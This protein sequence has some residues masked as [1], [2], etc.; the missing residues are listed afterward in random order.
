MSVHLKK[1]KLKQSKY[2]THT[3]Y[4]FNLE[5]LHQTREF[6]FDTAVTVFV[7]ENGSGKSTLLEACARA[8]RIHIWQSPGD[9]RYDLNLYEDQLYR[10]L[11]PEWTKGRVSGAFFAAH[12]FKD[13]TETLD[14]W[15]AADPG[16]LKYF[17]GKSLMT[18]SHGQSLM[19]Y[20]YN[21]YKIKG[22]Y[23][24]DEPETALSPK[25]QLELLNILGKYTKTGKAQFIIATHSPIL[26]ACNDAKIYDFDQIPVV[27]VE[28][29]ET[30]HYKIYRDFLTNKEKYL[31]C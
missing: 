13:F 23:L 15:A 31:E 6:S 18:L 11:E 2:P 26:L 10:Y 29:E 9:T 28:Y 1:I 24:L 21:R 17:G 3:S 27:P 19:A 12:F 5:L 25:S 16:Q 4:P 14:S 22:L 30:D 8:C 20:F 7:G